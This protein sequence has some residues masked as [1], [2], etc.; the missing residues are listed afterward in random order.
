VRTR[1]RLAALASAFALAFT[2][3]AGITPA[4]AATTPGSTYFP[5]TPARLLDTRFGTGA[6]QAPLGPNSSLDL[7]VVGVGGVPATGVTAV[8][9]NV[10]ATDA[11][12]PASF[13]TVYPAGT[14]QPLASNLNF[15]AGTIRTNAVKVAVPTTGDKAG[16]VTIYNL[17]GSVGVVADVNGWYSANGGAVGG[18]YVPQSPARIL[19]TRIGLGGFVL[20]PGQ[21]LDLQVTGM[22][23][24]PS[25]GVSAV[26]LNVTAILNG[27]ESFL[28][29][30]PSGTT[31]PLASNLNPVNGQAVPNLV[32]AR[33][34]TNGR[35]SIYSNLGFTDV[36]ADVQG[37][38][39]ATGTTLGATYFPLTPARDLDTRTG[40]GTGGTIGKMGAGQTLNLLVAGVNGVPLTG[41]SAVVLNVTA[42]GHTGADTYMT[43]FPSGTAR[44]LASNLNVVAGQT[45]P[46]LVIARVGT[47]GRVS[48]YNNAGA[49]DVIA[50]VQGWF[51]ANGA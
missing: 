45:I 13:L 2:M 10:I 21:T 31:R 32:V 28:T 43:V 29:V 20:S 22:G 40:V 24:V 25:A 9:L 37:W 16:K 44:P 5:L 27:P 48:I 15:G 51:L 33:L 1:R 36:V 49:V 12:A 34:G 18:T 38:Y 11:T 26:V 30:Y 39:T 14:P 3:L 50:D 8:M 6:P 17:A 4:H 7:T 35:V 46:N 42:A 23:G 41:V 47:D 19:D